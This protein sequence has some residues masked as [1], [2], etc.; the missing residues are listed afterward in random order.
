MGDKGDED[1]VRMK[2]KVNWRGKD[3]EGG[4]GG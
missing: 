3:G 2:I 1:L 4:G